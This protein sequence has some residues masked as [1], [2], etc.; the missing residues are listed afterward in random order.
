MGEQYS[1]AS[2]IGNAKSKNPPGI[3]A[4]HP[5]RRKPDKGRPWG[6]V[7]R[8]KVLG[9]VG[10]GLQDGH[11]PLC[12]SCHSRHLPFGDARASGD[13]LT[14]DGLEIVAKDVPLSFTI[15]LS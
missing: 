7:H 12:R 1:K 9:Q 10:A 14:K 11:P 5:N 13:A 4:R 3:R 2:E 8:F 6:W 15:A